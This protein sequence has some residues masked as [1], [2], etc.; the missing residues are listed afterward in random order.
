MKHLLLTLLLE[1]GAGAPRAKGLP[2]PRRL[3]HS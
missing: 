2:L 1:P 3:A